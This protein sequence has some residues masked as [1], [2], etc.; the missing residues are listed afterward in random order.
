MCSLA[1]GISGGLNL[2]QG[3]AMQG[4]AKEK[5][6][7]TFQQEVEGTQSAE[8]NKR[9]KQ[10]ALSEGKQ[11]KTVAARQDK[12]AK[13][14]DTL[15]ATKALLA[16]GQVGV[17]TN[18]LVMDQ[19][20]QGANYNEKIRQS[21]ESMNRQYLFDVKGTE[22]E[23]QGIRNRLR[24][25]TINAYN[26]IPSTGSILLG[27]ATSAFNTELGMGEDSFFRRG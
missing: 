24:S 18:L 6:E 25:N 14:I 27:A 10:L 7:G 26:Q 9:N 19:I 11:E 12:F 1:A 13:A 23:Y 4:A 15:V 17:T 22:A 5:A 8:D 21:I 16:K 3:L 2:F 20:R